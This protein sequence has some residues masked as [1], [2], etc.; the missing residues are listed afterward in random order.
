[1][2]SFNNTTFYNRTLFLHD[3]LV[4]NQVHIPTVKNTVKNAF[5]NNDRYMHEHKDGS[6][7]ILVQREIKQQQ[8]LMMI[9][10]IVM[11]I[12]MTVI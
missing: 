1:M 6:A 3:C 12:M 9:M 7:I 5:S 4:D 2:Y 10:T 8:M 11:M